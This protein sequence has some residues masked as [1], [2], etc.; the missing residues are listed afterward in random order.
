MRKTDKCAYCNHLRSDHCKGNV[1]HGNYKDTMR[2]VPKQRTHTCPSTHCEQ[3][4]CDCIVFK[5]AA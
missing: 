3:A 5:E 1:V 2:M 4:L